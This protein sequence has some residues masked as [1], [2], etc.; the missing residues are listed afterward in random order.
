MRINVL[1]IIWSL[2]LGGAERVV[3]NLAKGLDKT[4]FNPTVCC[5]NEAG[6]FA[7]ELEHLGIKV[8][9]LHKKS[10][11]DITV[12]RKLIA[13]I[14]EYNIQIVHTHL[15]GANFWGR[16]AAKVAGVPVIIATEHNVDIW[17]SNLNFALD[18]MLS[19]ISDK[20]IT[21]SRTVK[22]F[23]IKHGIPAGKIEVIYNGIDTDAR[24]SMLDARK[25][26]GLAEGESLLAI[27]GRIV[28]QKGH[29]YLFEALERLNGQHKVK[30]LVVGD[31]PLLNNLKV[32]AQQNPQLREKVI[33]TGLRK[34][35]RNLIEAVDILLMPS[36]REGLP[37][38]AL[39]AMAAG[40]PVIATNVGGTP[41]LIKD[42]DNGILIEPRDSRQLAEA[43]KKLLVNTPLSESL[44][45]RGQESVLN[46]FSIKDM[47][48]NTGNLYEQCLQSKFR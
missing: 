24:S 39:E 20:I 37:M 5:L 19:H 45:R 29:R 7:A 17:K 12:I 27:I 13:V 28:E 48:K 31:G 3:I 14:K 11:A 36:L 16:I 8:V 34:D 10:K 22:E 23:Y 1:Y 33:F 41:E 40:K 4:R 46:R 42:G 15:W 38:V 21:V 26:F 35:V 6:E 43:I 44:G 47:V 2:G 18:R 9:A 25:E 32:T 30:L